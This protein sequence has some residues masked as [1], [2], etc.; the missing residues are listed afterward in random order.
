MNNRFLLV[1][2]HAMFRVGLRMVLHAH[3]PDAEIAEAADAATAIQ[4]AQERKPDW[5]ILDLHLPDQNGLEVMRRL[6][7]ILPSTKIIISSEEA[8]FS[9]VTQTLKSGASAY[10]LKSSAA[11]EIPNA[12]RS[13]SAGKVYLCPGAN[14]VVLEHYRKGL[15]DPVTLPPPLSAREHEVLLAIA[16]GLRTKEIAARLQVGV[17]TVDTYRRRLMI[18]LACR[19]TAE[20]VRYALRAGLVPP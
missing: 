1:D 7:A 3:Y 16:D 2:D 12:I 4:S 11:G 20:L 5:V 13:V 6:L 14:E 15:A 10:I 19:S 18:K 8:D 9:Y 17:K